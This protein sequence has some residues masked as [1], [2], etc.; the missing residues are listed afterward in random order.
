MAQI[1]NDNW[2]RW[3]VEYKKKWKKEKKKRSWDRAYQLQAC[4]SEKS[5][6]KR[7]RFC[8]IEGLAVKD[9]FNDKNY[10]I[11]QKNKEEKSW[12]TSRLVCFG[13]VMAVKLYKKGREKESTVKMLEMIDGKN[14]RLCQQNDEGLMIHS[15]IPSPGQLIMAYNN[16]RLR[17]MPLRVGSKAKRTSSGVRLDF[18]WL[19]NVYSRTKI[20][21]SMAPSYLTHQK[22]SMSGHILL[23][24]EWVQNHIGSANSPPKEQSSA[25]LYVKILWLSINSQQLKFSDFSSLIM[26]FLNPTASQ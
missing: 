1:K 16:F 8:M 26:F 15:C 14:P 18:L 13:K 21:C 3:N 10:K 17:Y 9:C 19:V 5:I 2:A 25:L 20:Y 6:S 7:M 11:K 12:R 4:Y 23:K 22:C 24:V